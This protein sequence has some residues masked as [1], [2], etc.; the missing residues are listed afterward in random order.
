MAGGNIIKEYLT[1]LALLVHADLARN[2]DWEKI[3]ILTFLDEYG[4]LVGRNDLAHFKDLVLE[5]L[6]A[7]C[8][9]IFEEAGIGGHRL[10]KGVLVKIPKSMHITSK[11]TPVKD[12]YGPLLHKILNDY[13]AVDESAAR[14]ILEAGEIETYRKSD[15][16]FHERRF[17][18]FEYFQFDGVSHR[19]NVG[20]DKEVLTT[21]IYQDAIV[22][23]PH[24][25]RT[26]NSQ[27]IFSMQALS[28]CTYLK[29][30]AGVFKDL[31]D[32]H[33]QVRM[34]GQA[35]VEKEFIRSLKFE[36]LFR[37]QNAKDR[38][39]FFREKYPALENLIPHTVIASFLGITPVSFS[40]LRN[41][42]AK[43]GQ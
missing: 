23:T 42:L 25:A 19:Y 38:L 22:I 32:Q 26:T 15:V 7:E 40:R 4:A 30:P 37:A 6:F 9:Q 33:T 21:G 11:S 13:T 10:E 41:E 27:S 34:F 17:N 29:V 14:I 5:F 18:A 31:R 16:I 8:I 3:E 24:F 39:L 43:A 1:S 36:V 35:V 12:D 20:D 28:D 2:Y